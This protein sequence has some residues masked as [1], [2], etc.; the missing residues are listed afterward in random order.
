MTTLL[1]PMQEVRLRNLLLY[2]FKQTTKT[3]VG[4]TS[5]H[6]L[7]YFI[8]FDYYEI[9]EKH[10]LGLTYHKRKFGPMLE[11]LDGILS[12]MAGEGTISSSKRRI[13]DYIQTEWENQEEPDTSLF[14]SEEL[15][16]INWEISRLAH[17]TAAE[18][19]NFSHS[20]TPWMVAENGE[21][22]DYELVFYR[23]DEHLVGENEDV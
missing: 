7:L 1:S 3:P 16:H 12:V 5:L 22:L 11:C 15:E 10:L 8:D 17:L 14:D 18:I 19:S 20:D 9:N 6:K 2:I 4:L 23:D 21:P 13:I